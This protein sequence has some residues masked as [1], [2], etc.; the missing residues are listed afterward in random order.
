[1]AR[2]CD[3]YT[4]V[5]PLS[6]G[7]GLAVTGVA[8]TNP[9]TAPF[10]APIGTMAAGFA[11]GIN[12]TDEGMTIKA[13]FDTAMNKT[14]HQIF[15]E[16][17]LTDDCLAD[18]KQDVIGEGTSTNDFVNNSQRKHFEEGLV[19]VIRA[20]LERH[21]EN[22]NWYS[23]ES[24]DN[25]FIERASKDIAARLIKTI[26]SVFEEEDLLKILKAI[27]DRSDIIRSD[28]CKNR[29]DDKLEHEQLMRLLKEISEIISTQYANNNSADFNSFYEYTKKS[30]RERR[31]M[32]IQL[33]WGSTQMKSLILMHL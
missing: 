18:L 6:A 13:K 29:E 7:L 19:I 5:G 9:T 8:L 11:S 25:D 24:W 4:P 30:L 15:V 2:K 23:G 33:L 32:N 16:Y 31:S 26:N 10:A 17:N 22:L 12:L 20:I 14:W 21:K 27:A 1:M 3:G 28:L